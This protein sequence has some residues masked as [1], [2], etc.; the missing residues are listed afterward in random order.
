MSS[1]VTVNN[2]TSGPNDITADGKVSLPG[3]SEAEVVVTNTYEK[4]D[5]SGKASLTINKQ[6]EVN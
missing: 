4:I 3:S 2:T 1:T 6:I 5:V